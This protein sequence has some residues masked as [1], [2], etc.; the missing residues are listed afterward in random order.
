M[1]SEMSSI[2]QGRGDSAVQ[3]HHPEH[4]ARH[5]HQ[6][7][8]S[9]HSPPQPVQALNE[10]KER[11]PDDYQPSYINTFPDRA[12]SNV[13][14]NQTPGINNRQPLP[15]ASPQ[16]PTVSPSDGRLKSSFANQTGNES[17]SNMNVQPP[18]Q[19]SNQYQSSFNQTYPS[20]QQPD[21]ANVSN[22]NQG[23]TFQQP[24]TQDSTKKSQFGGINE[25]KPV[26]LI[27]TR[28][29]DKQPSNFS[30]KPP[31]NNANSRFSETKPQP[32]QQ[33]TAQP[34]T[35]PETQP[36][37]QPETQPRVQQ[38][39][40]TE[41]RSDLPSVKKTDPQEDP[42]DPHQ[43]YEIVEKL[44][45]LPTEITQ[46]KNDKN[47]TPVFKPYIDRLSD[48]NQENLA[49]PNSGYFKQKDGSFYKGQFKAIFKHGLGF[50]RL[51]DSSEYVGFFIVDKFDVY[52]RL[53]K[54]DGTVYLG[55]WRDNKKNGQGKLMVKGSGVYEGEFINDKRDGKGV[56]VWV[57]NSRYEGE[58]SDDCMQGQGT[59]TFPD[60][61]AYQ[62]EFFNNKFDGVG[63]LTKDGKV[64]YKGAYVQDKKEGLGTYIDENGTK[65]T[66]YWNQGVPKGKFKV[67]LPDG[68]VLEE[69]HK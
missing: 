48:Y 59:Y 34:V 35:Q 27:N 28:E 49:L 20:N 26:S 37:T 54:P 17:R 10:G 51:Q 19:I 18:P 56:F 9:I 67:E 13:P 11:R 64:V 23:P 6:V 69:D 5:E 8:H 50:L 66:G 30:Q 43:V 65:Y 68:T 58:F 60:G 45:E 12:A 24:N 33:T 42:T 40:P 32:E 53:I 61:R 47:W 38:E 36:A 55:E 22:G 2:D 25:E 41:K 1:G 63:V 52:G 14:E 21:K 39:V 44:A 57:D 3:V 62:G 15:D 7:G 29:N 16:M 31:S 46:I 4:R